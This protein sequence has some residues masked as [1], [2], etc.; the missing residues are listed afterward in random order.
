MSQSQS[1]KIYIPVPLEEWLKSADDFYICESVTLIKLKRPWNING[2]TIALRNACEK[3][4]MR[5]YGNIDI[6]EVEISAEAKELL[7]DE[8]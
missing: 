8:N 5:R 6:P 2:A 1:E 7:E 4:W 3:E